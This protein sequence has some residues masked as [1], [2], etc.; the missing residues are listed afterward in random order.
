MTGKS[1]EAKKNKQHLIS[2]PQYLS[3]EELNRP[4]PVTDRLRRNFPEMLAFDRNSMKAVVRKLLISKEI[5]DKV[6]NHWSSA[7]PGAPDS[8]GGNSDDDQVVSTVKKYCMLF[9]SVLS[10]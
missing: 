8:I 3:V 1:D 6:H 5:R 10:C 4:A 9:V 7:A 2:N